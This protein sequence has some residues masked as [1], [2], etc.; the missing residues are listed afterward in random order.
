VLWGLLDLQRAVG[1]EGT[2]VAAD[3]YTVARSLPEGQAFGTWLYSKRLGLRLGGVEVPV[4]ARRPP[5][6]R[7]D[8]DG[9]A[10]KSQ[11]R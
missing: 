8:L 9:G 2:A 10:Q 7:Y 1:L 11:G 5:S 3:Y 4:D 6:G